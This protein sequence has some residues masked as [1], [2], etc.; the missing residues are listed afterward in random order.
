MPVGEDFRVNLSE[1]EQARIAQDIDRN[2]R[3]KL[4]NGMQDLWVRLH[5]VVAKM[6][7]TLSDP[8]KGFHKTL[9]TN[10]EDLVEI[11]PQ[12][13][14][15]GDATRSRPSSPLPCEDGRD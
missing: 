2:S 8:E 5:K 11:L 15:T 9:V 13:N 4:Q 3:E 14:I 10:I 7:G 12:L 6:A 1:E